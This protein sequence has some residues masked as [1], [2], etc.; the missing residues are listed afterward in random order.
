[1]RRVLVRR[2]DRA[3]E[4][5]RPHNRWRWSLPPVAVP[6]ARCRHPA[7]RR[8]SATMRAARASAPIRAPR[9]FRSSPPSRWSRAASNAAAPFKPN[10][11]PISRR[12]HFRQRPL[13]QRRAATGRSKTRCT[14]FLDVTFRED[15]SRIRTGHGA[16]NMAVVRHFALNLVRQV[17]DKRSIKR[18]RKRAAWDP[19]YLL[20]ILGPLRPRPC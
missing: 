15:L 10:G 16:N 17:A 12:A 19:Q 9:A 14:G 4:T 5:P 20:E 18:R 7:S 6:I 8:Y 11:D 2:R 13:P 3:A 1:M